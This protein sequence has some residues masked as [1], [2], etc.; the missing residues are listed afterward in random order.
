MFVFVLVFP[1]GRQA[2]VKARRNPPE[3]GRRRAHRGRLRREGDGAQDQLS[4]PAGEILCLVGARAS[5][6]LRFLVNALG[7]FPRW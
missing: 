6:V 3:A 5:S 4:F 2:C 7:S 1:A